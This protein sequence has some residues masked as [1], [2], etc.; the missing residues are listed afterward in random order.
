MTG[1]GPD[2]SRHR[3][4]KPLPQ[5]QSFAPLWERPLAATSA[6][7]WAGMMEKGRTNPGSFS[8]RHPGLDPGSMSNG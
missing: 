5:V 3:G 1:M 4:Y 7:A 2:E 6:G 8:T